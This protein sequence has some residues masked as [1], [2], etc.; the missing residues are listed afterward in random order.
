MT[1]V[2][3]EVDILVLLAV[4]RS[5]IVTIFVRWIGIIGYVRLRLSSASVPAGAQPTTAREMNCPSL[6]KYL[7]PFQIAR[8]DHSSLYST[9][10]TFSYPAARYRKPL[11]CENQP[12]NAS[13]NMFRKISE[14]LLSTVSSFSSGPSTPAP[15]PPST[16][17]S[18]PDIT[19]LSLGSAST[20]DPN[21]HQGRAAV[22]RQLA[23][24]L[25]RFGVPVSEEDCSGCQEH[26]QGCDEAGAGDITHVQ[27]P[28][29]FDVDWETD[30]LGSSKPQPRQ[31][32]RRSGAFFAR[33]GRRG[34]SRSPRS[35]S[36]R[37]GNQTGRMTTRKTRPGSHII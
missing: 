15:E 29:G 28:R 37:L 34:S 21:S 31:V 11:K 35:S 26:E 14:N 30:L 16:G 9:P 18:T 7:S 4:L 20:A 10:V 33:R 19:S 13:T 36:S 6:R 23:D 5:V 27:Y 2:D 24:E 17:T 3:C 25:A 22:E 32:S 8:T 1:S 12:T